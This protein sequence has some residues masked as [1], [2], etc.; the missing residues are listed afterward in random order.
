MQSERLLGGHAKVAGSHL[1]LLSDHGK[2]TCK[3]Y[4]C[5]SLQ[6]LVVVFEN[7]WATLRMLPANL[8]V[9]GSVLRLRAS[10]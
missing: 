4:D 2:V 10:C 8:A 9:Y 6:C 5:R 7:H 1:I 3:L